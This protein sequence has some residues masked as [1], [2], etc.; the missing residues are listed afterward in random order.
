[1]VN[2][3][4][5][6]EAKLLACNPP[7]SCPSHSGDHATSQKYQIECE[8]YLKDLQT[9]IENTVGS[10]LLMRKLDRFVMVLSVPITYIAT[11]WFITVVTTCWC[12]DVA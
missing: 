9:R 11:L 2:I 7:L 1:M 4:R 3:F 10:L 5:C 12:P 8:W 6:N